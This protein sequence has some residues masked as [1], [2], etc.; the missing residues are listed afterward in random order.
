[1]FWY[2]NKKTN[3]AEIFGGVT[4]ILRHENLEDTEYRSRFDECFSRKK[5]NIFEDETYRIERKELIKAARQNQSAGRT[6]KK[7]MDL[8]ETVD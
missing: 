7:I 6:S 8:P 4:A 1:M 5:L 3:T 2:L